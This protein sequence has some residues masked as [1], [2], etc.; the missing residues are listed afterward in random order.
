MSRR[1]AFAVIFALLLSLT[2]GPAAAAP[3]QFTP[4]AL[5]LGDPY[6]PGDGNGGYDVEHYLLDVRYDPATDALTG[7]ATIT[8]RASQ[9]LSAFN[10]DFDDPLN[11]SGVSVN[12][13]P[14]G[15]V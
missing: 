12:G 9:N 13:R 6:F 8:A 7:V 10:L 2:A 1:P 5:D 4:G 11:A 15:S 3:P 14:A